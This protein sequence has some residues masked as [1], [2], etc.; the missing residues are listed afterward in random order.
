MRNTG[1]TSIEMRYCSCII[2]DCLCTVL[3]FAWGSLS[4]VQSLLLNLSSSGVCY[5]GMVRANYL[6]ICSTILFEAL[7]NHV[8]ATSYDDN[9]ELF[10][11]RAN[12]GVLRYCT[13]LHCRSAVDL[14]QIGV[15]STFITLVENLTGFYTSSAFVC[16]T[17]FNTK[18]HKIIVFVRKHF[19][20]L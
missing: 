2:S 20:G 5:A 18:H 1:I 8:I 12:T 4:T 16:S 7:F 13:C 19:H 15:C 17:F 3:F 14:F 11:N 10:T 6:V 9:D